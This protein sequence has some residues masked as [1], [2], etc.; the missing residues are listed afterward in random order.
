MVMPVLTLKGMYDSN[1]ASSIGICR[2]LLVSGPV[3]MTV[4][5]LTAR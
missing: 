2:N 4:T 5:G 3:L 1:H